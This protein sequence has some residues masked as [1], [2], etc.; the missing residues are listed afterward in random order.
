MTHET[1]RRASWTRTGGRILVGLLLL[2]LVAPFVV[3]AVPGVVGAE[4][5]YVVL[6]ASMTPDIAP[7]DVVV[8]DDVDPQTVRVGDVIVFEKR[9][10]D[11]IPVTHRVVAIDTDAD[12]QRVFQTKGDANEDP[13][14]APVP[15][16][17]VVGRVRFVIPV[18]GH[19]IQFVGTTTGFV[20][21]V[22]VPL[23]LLVVSELLDLIRPAG[24]AEE[25]ESA[26]A[27]AV[28]TDAPSVTD[29]S[30]P[31]DDDAVEADGEMTLTPADLTWT[32]GALGAFAAY[33]A[34]AAYQRPSGV[35]V[36]VAV[37]VGATFALAVGLRQFGASAPAMADGGVTVAAPAPVTVPEVR[38][39][40]HGDAAGPR[41]DVRSLADLRTVA[42][43]VGRPVVR[44]A[45]GTH[46]VFDGVVTYAYAGEPDDWMLAW[47]R[48][49][50]SG[51][52]R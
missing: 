28:A 35:S 13:D 22:V 26:D 20:A 10:G 33:A 6:T 18:I 40:S 12:G 25:A 1:T 2:A 36:A 45:D 51:V 49:H 32:S 14:A 29:A 17:R 3:Y 27:T 30:I 31:T 16:A 9:A 24:D 41:L 52:A 46:L 48:D 44:D 19:V 15:A 11:R 39:V 5:S 23:G 50:A 42:A 4:G 43:V 38:L 37:A 21:L 47:A 7:G 8:V 34:Y